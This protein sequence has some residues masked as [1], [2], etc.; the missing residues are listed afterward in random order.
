MRIVALLVA[1][2]LGTAAQAAG[3]A[4]RVPARLPVPEIEGPSADQPRRV[5]PIGSYTLALT[6]M[7]DRC[8]R[9]SAE[10]G[11]GCRRGRGFILHGLWPDGEGRDWPQWCAPAPALPSALL[12]ARYCATPSAQLL[13][14][15]WAKHGTCMPGYDPARYFALSNRLFAGLATPDM[16]GLSRAPGLSAR[17]FAAAWT[18]ANRLPR[19][20]VRLS[21]D[22]DGWL[23]EVWLCLDRRFRPQ[24][25]PATQGGAGA[26]EP[27][28]IWRVR[29]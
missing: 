19:D 10:D 7:P 13:Q 22:R 21:L 26:D 20:T 16:N 23:K 29:R 18:A 15:E 8:R 5:L 1:L 6:W 28:R 4:C 27:V 25:C 24:R 14:H 3:P 9:G 17:R 12:R 2:A 11:M